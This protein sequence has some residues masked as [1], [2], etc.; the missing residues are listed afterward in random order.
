ME[1][2]ELSEIKGQEESAQMEEGGS[3]DL[4]ERTINKIRV[5]RAPATLAKKSQ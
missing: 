4:R 1:V 5:M 2:W 3:K